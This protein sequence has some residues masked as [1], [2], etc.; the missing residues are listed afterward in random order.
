LIDEM[1]GTQ[2]AVQLAKAGHDGLHVVEAGLVAA[3]D[4]DVLARAVADDRVLVT[5][6]GQDLI[7]LLDQRSAAGLGLTPVVIALK[8]RLGSGGQGM[9]LALAD[10]LVRWAEQ[11]PEPYRHVHWLP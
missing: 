11:N 1:F 4:A 10:R 7:P 5:E 6:N 3:S 8:R 9:N 2:V